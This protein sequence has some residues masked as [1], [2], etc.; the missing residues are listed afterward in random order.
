[1]AETI[2]S[3]PLSLATSSSSGPARSAAT[4]STLLSFKAAFAG[5]DTDEGRASATID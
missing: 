1:M 3:I 2:T 4:I 5:F